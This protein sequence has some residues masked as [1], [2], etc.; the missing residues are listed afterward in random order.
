MPNILGCCCSEC[1]C[2]AILAVASTIRRTGSIDLLL[3]R[4]NAIAIW[5]LNVLGCKCW[6]YLSPPLVTCGIAI[7]AVASTIRQIGSIDLLLYRNNA[8]AIAICCFLMAICCFLMAFC[9]AITFA[10]YGADDEVIEIRKAIAL[11][12]NLP[13]PDANFRMMGCRNEFWTPSHTNCLP[14]KRY[15]LRD[16]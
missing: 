15:F 14:K 12:Y 16:R 5:W 7:L 4:N 8:I 11:T 10:I 2:V 3:Y 6:S 1:W 9:V 13:Q